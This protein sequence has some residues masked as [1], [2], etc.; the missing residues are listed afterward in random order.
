MKLAAIL[1]FFL[2]STGS[3]ARTLTIW[4]SNANIKKAILDVAKKFEK[5]YE[6]KVH[7]DVLNKNLSTQFKTAALSGKGP[8]FFAWAH[9]IVG[10]LVESGF[11][12]PLNLS[13]KF[14]SQFLEV[15]LNAFT[16]K[17]KIYGYPYA[18]EAVALIYNQD[19]ISEPP[20]ELSEVISIHKSLKAKNKDQFA[21]LYDYRNFF[22]SFPVLSAAGGYIFKNNDGVLNIKDIGLNNLGAIKGVKLLKELVDQGVIPSST[23]YGIAEKIMKDGN[24]AMT[25]NGPWSLGTLKQSKINYKVAPLPLIDGQSPKPFVGS[26]GFYIRRTSPNKELAQEFIE[27]YL[28]TKEG[29]YTLYKEDPR[30]PSRKDVIES[31]SQTD[32]DVKGFML[33]AQNGIPTPNVPEMSIVWPAMG[34][35]LG[36]IMEGNSNISEGLSDAVNQ[37]KK[38]IN[39]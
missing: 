23:D 14:K 18:L 28:L 4:T 36:L 21:L 15:A 26:H 1:V 34:N 25:I 16:Y 11:I 9:D 13:P 22:F 30:L 2:I 24:L 38:G 8:D 7:V 33:S 29:N 5:E 39:N 6:I 27:N 20:K 10:E 37:I 12:E 31:V 32:P 17:G 3:W 19:L 35:A